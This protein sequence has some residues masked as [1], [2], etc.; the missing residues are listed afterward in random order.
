M[1]ALP[2]DEAGKYVAAAY[3][4]FLALVLITAGFWAIQGQLYASMPKYVFRMVGEHASPEW[5]ANINPLVV[6][7]C[8]VPVTQLLKRTTPIASIA[9]ANTSSPSRSGRWSRC[10][11]GKSPRSRRRR[12]R[13]SSSRAS[14]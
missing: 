14:S 4:V 6:V 9:I 13:A 1:P 12:R 10:S 7:L 3:L 8:V 11:N 5:Y 2:L